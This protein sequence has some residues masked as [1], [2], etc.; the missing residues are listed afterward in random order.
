MGLAYHFVT[1]QLP[2][3]E[4]RVVLL[5]C[6]SDEADQ[7]F[8]FVRTSILR[9]KTCCVELARQEDLAALRHRLPGVLAGVYA[10]PAVV[11]LS[12]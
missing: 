8:V 12:V 4:P 9:E 1:S 7:C 3:A 11:P 6:L 5:S 10:D 2:S